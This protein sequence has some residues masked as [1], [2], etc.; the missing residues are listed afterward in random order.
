M[1]SKGLEPSGHFVRRV[2]FSSS[3]DLTRF[4]GAGAV[5]RRRSSV[6]TNVARHAV[7]SVVS[8]LFPSDC[9]LCGLPL[10]TSSYLPVCPECLESIQP[11]SG[12]R[13][14]LCGERLFAGMA[15]TLCGECLAERPPFVKASAYGSYEAGL[16]ELIHLL[17]Y[18]AVKPAATVLGRML[19]EAIED[20]VPEFLNPDVPLNPPFPKE[21]KD[22]APDST[23][24]LKPKERLNGAPSS[25]PVDLPLVVPV[26]LHATKLRQRGFNQAELIARAAIKQKPLGLELELAPELLVRR[27][28]TESQVGYTRQQRIANLRGAFGVS[29]TVEARDILLVDDVFTTGTTVS[30]CA[31]VLRRNGARRVWVAT[32]ARVLKAEVRFARMEREQEEV[33]AMAARA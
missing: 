22:G 31:R 17:K 29:G 13:C 8:L 28:A 4:E 3:G 30:E 19:A 32:V 7:D 1:L 26:P 2:V 24:L 27:R 16:R 20:L 25:T 23:T 10:A 15:T 5:F 11:I 33:L 21:G 9:R 6:A 12:E 18:E 14:L